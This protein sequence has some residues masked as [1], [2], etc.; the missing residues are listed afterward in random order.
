MVFLPLVLVGCNFVKIQS[1]Q[2]TIQ[3]VISSSK[4]DTFPAPDFEAQD[5]ISGKKIRL[6][7]FKGK[8]VVINFWF[9]GC[10]ASRWEAPSFRK[11]ADNNPDIVVL[12]V[13]DPEN[14]PGDSLQSFV[15]EFGWTFPVLLDEKRITK[16]TDSGSY[17]IGQIT[18]SFDEEMVF[19]T[20]FLINS[21]GEVVGKIVNYLD[22]ETSE[23]KDVLENLRNGKLRWY[24]RYLRRLK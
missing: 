15:K 1:T 20:T 19:P 24:Y 8:P 3:K 9:A 21:D 13:T 22:W 12:S 23:M 14:N 17:Q 4:N 7:T 11:F 2:E 18:N 6:S 5:F 10:P 16:Q